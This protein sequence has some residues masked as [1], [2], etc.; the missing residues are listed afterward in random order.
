MRQFF[1]ILLLLA[2]FAGLLGQA[3]NGVTAAFTFTP[4]NACSGTQLTF[5]ANTAGNPATGLVY[6]W[7]FGNGSALD[8]GTVVTY[9]YNNLTGGGSQNF[10]VTLM[11][12][13]NGVAVACD[14][15]VMTVMVKQLP[16]ISISTPGTT[17][18]GTVISKC[19]A[20]LTQHTLSVLNTSTTFATNS[21]YTINWGDGSPTQN[22]TNTTFTMVTP[23]THVYT[24]VGTKIITITTTGSN[25]CTRTK[26]YTFFLGS[27]PGS[28]LSASGNT[29]GLCAPVS[30]SASVTLSATSNNTPGT[31]YSVLLNGT[32]I[33]GFTQS[34]L[35]PTISYNFLESSCG[36]SYFGQNNTFTLLLRAENP[37]GYFESTVGPITI[38]AAPTAAIGVDYPT[39]QCP[40]ET[41][42]FTNE[43][44]GAASISVTNECDDSQNVAWTISP[45]TYN[46]VS[47]SLFA[48][49]FGVQFTQPG[50][51]AVTM[52][53]NNAS[54]S[55]GGD[56]L[57][58]FVTVLTPP[59][60][61]AYAQVVP[62][63]DSCAPVQIT[64]H[65][66]S[67]GTALSYEWSVVPATGV[68]FVSGTDS[69]STNPTIKFNNAGTY[70]VVLTAHNSCNDDIWDTTIVVRNR[71][72]LSLSPIGDG[73]APMTLGFSSGN[74]LANE[75]G[76]PTTYS[77]QFSGANPTSSTAKYPL[78]ILYSN[79]GTY[80]VTVT[81]TNSCGT[82]SAT[83]SFVLSM[84]PSVLATVDTDTLCA[85][86]TI[87]CTDLS[88]GN[89]S[90]LWSISP[91]TGWNYVA[92]FG[93]TTA[94][95]K[96][97]FTTVGTYIVSLGVTNECGTVNINVDT[98]VV[99][100]KP[101]I[102]IADIN[103]CDS[104]ITITQAMTTSSNGGFNT[105]NWNWSSTGSPATATGVPPK[106]FTF[107][108]GSTSY[109]TVTLANACG[110]R[111]DTV[112]V[113]ISAT[114]TVSITNPPIPAN[115][116]GPYQVN[117]NNNSQ[118]I[119]SQQWYVNG[120]TANTGTGYSYVQATNAQSED[121]KVSFTAAGTYA[122]VCSL[123]NACDTLAWTKTFTVVLPP[124]LTLPTISASCDSTINLP[125]VAVNNGGL[126]TTTI[127]QT[128]GTPAT[129]TGLD[130][131]VVTYAGFGVYPI[132]VT[133]SNVC[134]TI[135][136]NADIQILPHPVVAISASGIPANNCGPATITINNQ[137]QHIASQQWAITGPSGGYSYQGGTN[138]SSVSPSILFSQAGTYTISAALSNPCE[139]P[140]WDTTFTI[141]L[142]PT[143]TV[144]PINSDCTTFTTSPSATFNSGGNPNATILWSAVGSNQGTSNSAN[145]TFTY[146][147]AGTYTITATINNGCPAVSSSVSFQVFEFVPISLTDNPA[148]LCS[149][150]GTFQLITTPNASGTW[151]GPNCPASGLLTMSDFITDGNYTFS[152]H[153]GSGNCEINENVTIYIQTLAV[154]AGANIAVCDIYGGCFNLTGATPAGGVYTGAGVVGSQFCP[155]VAGIGTHTIAYTYTHPTTGCAFVD[156]RVITVNAPPLAAFEVIT[157]CHG[158]VFNISNNTTPDIQSATWTLPNSS[159]ATV[160]AIDV[161][162][163]NYPI[164][165]DYVITM[166]ATDQHGCKDTVAHDIHI[167]P[168]ISG[169][170]SVSDNEICFGESIILTTT[171]TGEGI[172]T[173][174][175]D[176]FNI[177]QTP[178]PLSEVVNYPSGIFDTTY[179]VAYSYGNICD[180]FDTSA[181][182]LVHALPVADVASEFLTYCSGQTVQLG[183]AASLN[184]E[185]D[186]LDAGNGQVFNNTG[187]NTQEVVY[188]NSGNTPIAVTVTYTASNQCA[189]DVA[190]LNLTI[191]PSD[192]EAFISATDPNACVG[193]TICLSSSS[194]FG[195]TLTWIF[196]DQIN[197]ANQEAV[198]HIFTTAGQHTV[199]L[200]AN[201]CGYDSD[202]I[203]I[204][205]NPL[206][207]IALD[208]SPIAVCL[209]ESVQVTAATPNQDAW[210]HFGDG[211]TTALD[212]AIYVYQGPGI[213]TVTAYAISIPFGCIAYTTDNVTIRPLPEAN[214]LLPPQPYCEGGQINLTA[215]TPTS[216]SAPFT[217]A[218]ELSNGQTAVG[219]QVGLPI[220]QVGSFDLSLTVS[221]QFGCTDDTLYLPIIVHPRPEAA[222]TVTA[223]QLCGVPVDVTFTNTSTGALGYLWDSNGQ[224]STAVSPIFTYDF[225]DTYTTT[226]IAS[227]QFGCLDT[228]TADF[229][230]HAQ[231]I[232]TLAVEDQI[233]LG[234]SVTFTSLTNESVTSYTYVTDDGNS[235]TS[236]DTTLTYTYDEVGVYFPQLIVGNEV[237][238]D[239]SVGNF[240][241]VN[242][243]PVADFGYSAEVL[244][245][246]GHL[247]GYVAFTNL[248]ENADSYYW[249]FGDGS[250]DSTETDPAHR[251]FEGLHT[252]L[253]TLVA[254]AT[255]GCADTITKELLTTALNGLYIPNVITP[256]SGDP[257]TSLFTPKGA[258]LKN[259]DLWIYTEWGEL[260][261]HT[262]A[263]NEFGSPTESWD[264]TFQGKTLPI[265]AYTWR[266]RGIFNDNSAW[267][268]MDFGDGR[269]RIEGTIT[270][271]R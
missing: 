12:F 244:P 58:Q 168:L 86:E 94:T 138:A 148:N 89:T 198:C 222:F 122:V 173:T 214:F 230:T 92:G 213:Y 145:P 20:A 261:W 61:E 42:T 262:N 193:D 71:P 209:G 141:Y 69:T 156:T 155:N 73:C 78:G 96:V 25:G 44:M 243:V 218:W 160:N 120:S 91:N 165:G 31:V 126:T 199:V 93:S 240:V 37:C 269:L 258:N 56:T 43:S 82:G 253:V 76:L 136:D 143:V 23:I 161:V 166:I 221:D 111:K 3:C 48:N 115:N 200:Q 211:D 57:T 252:Y 197:V 175:Q 226:L 40:N 68:Q 250:S 98:I 234:Q 169:S 182:I 170:L 247:S 207:M 70:Q 74:F 112:A 192:V 14:T 87:T 124:T 216:G 123:Y 190:T 202:T 101:T 13:A 220:P 256:N 239:T 180:A 139:S 11:V 248:S 30:V 26:V 263:L 245:N 147:T 249:D 8:S 242:L 102:A 257:N 241:K 28:G 224:T 187:G 95:T 132:I 159:Q 64:F 117:F 118:N 131:G 79:A 270:V 90:R 47:G 19:G 232:A 212:D 225:E 154:N 97:N 142:P 45:A 17:I 110:N 195:A 83:A 134:D 236:T 191:T 174:L 63:G 75:G 65:N 150:G 129:F 60:A 140:T 72:V 125:A 238:F 1:N 164:G 196:D 81:A 116:C 228:A 201:G 108:S 99:R 2:P 119:V 5:T 167:I 106:T 251:Y 246:T 39:H 130:P 186:I 128:G 84:L 7:N 36:E 113:T 114:P 204:Q 171:N 33:E 144:A 38:N 52:I 35:P 10:D 80:T 235:I 194:T 9:S 66:Q 55:C 107:S 188:L 100:A 266:A 4:N 206:P 210:L 255:T 153:T 24:S 67:T 22:L 219:Q 183:T 21:S 208:I 88:T 16:D 152:F 185:T 46:I 146:P 176:A 271:V 233:C 203:L 177:V 259:F 163:I 18:S 179:I 158:A 215:T 267:L 237:C 227:N 184:V 50:T 15:Q 149:N 260:V 229:A 27:N 264:G 127:W 151:S 85:P 172:T 51:Y 137:S 54:Y 32:F 6:Q 223:A 104:V 109:I 121:P 53:V 77:W 254:T 217:Y 162:G 135:T 133:A 265:G 34:S 59:T 157:Q 41:Y 29:I 231:P 103:S 181:S 205:V 189:T 178:A 105:L 49:A 268:G 62:A